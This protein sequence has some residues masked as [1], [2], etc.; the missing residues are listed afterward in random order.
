MGRQEIPKNWVKGSLGHPW[1]PRVVS[2]GSAGGPLG[3]FWGAL[4]EDSGEDFG[5]I[6]DN[7][8]LSIF[9]SG[10][11]YL[12]SPLKTENEKRSSQLLF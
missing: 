10:T 7:V 1:D 2:R 8:F 4:L 6:L 9:R 11:M 12:S 3:V 5:S